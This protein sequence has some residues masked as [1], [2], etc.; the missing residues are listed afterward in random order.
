MAERDWPTATDLTN[1]A[2]DATSR[3]E[4]RLEVMRRL[5][6]VIEADW[7]VFVDIHEP[8]SRSNVI[9][10]DTG[11]AEAARRTV[12]SSPRE[13]QRAHEGLRRHGAIVDTNIYDRHE[14]LRLP[15]IANHQ[16]KWGV[17]SNLI[18]QWS[19]RSGTSVFVNLGRSRGRY[20]EAHERSARGLVKSLAVADGWP[21][22]DAP[23]SPVVGSMQLTERQTEIARYVCSGFSN[24]QIARACGI[25]M[26]TVRNHL[27][28]LFEQF[29]VCTRTEL[30]LRLAGKYSKGQ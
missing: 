4:F 17:T 6:R 2:F 19:N 28:R 20:T 22:T 8:M 15:H 3:T 27:V 9:E 5:M 14:W 13:L 30:A 23:P 12:C 18:M 29:G 16:A 10:L 24:P 7:V 11:A 1:L 25:S 26:F 21:S